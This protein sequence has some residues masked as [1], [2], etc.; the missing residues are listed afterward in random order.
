MYREGGTAFSNVPDNVDSVLTSSISSTLPTTVASTLPRTVAN[1]A[2]STILHT[3]SSTQPSSLGSTL[4]R[5]LHVTL[6]STMQPNVAIS[7]RST[8]Q[9]NTGKV[10][11]QM[12][13][14]T[15]TAMR[16]VTSQM[17]IFNYTP[18]ISTKL[19]SIYSNAYLHQTSIYLYINIAVLDFPSLISFTGKSR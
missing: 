12:S 2:L 10:T 9:S 19:V 1:T 8:I 6:T 3:I 5:N 11:G 13:P 4:F 16:I 15:T 17:A 14:Q 18:K 7:S